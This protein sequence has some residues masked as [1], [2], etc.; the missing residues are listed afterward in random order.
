M[1]GF[2]KLL[3]AIVAVSILAVIITGTVLF[4]KCEED[5]LAECRYRVRD[6]H[7]NSYHAI[8]YKELP[9]SCVSLV[10]EYH[11]QVIICGQY[12]I[13]CVK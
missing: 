2:E 4:V 6:A 1:S 11:K 13:E 7:N 5:K 10:N 8:S 9:G 12:T 3:D